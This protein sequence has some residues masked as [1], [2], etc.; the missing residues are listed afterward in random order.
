LA[1]NVNVDLKPFYTNIGTG[2]RGALIALIVLVSSIWL[3]I[4]SAPQRDNELEKILSSHREL[5]V[6]NNTGPSGKGETNVLET[7]EDLV[8]ASEILLK[9]ILLHE[10]NEEYIFWLY[11]GNVEYR[12]NLFKKI[13]DE[14]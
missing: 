8:K 14:S 5:I 10:S 12:Y 9:P 2:Q 7:F 11:D 4:S 3:I 6:K 1:E 13:V